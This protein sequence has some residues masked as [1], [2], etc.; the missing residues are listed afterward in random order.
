MHCRDQIGKIGI[1]NHTGR[2]V[3]RLLGRLC[4]ISGFHSF[5][6]EY[7]NTVVEGVGCQ[8]P[9]LQLSE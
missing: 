8:S 5:V 3:G 4:R 1:G 2:S 9:D 7:L 6:V